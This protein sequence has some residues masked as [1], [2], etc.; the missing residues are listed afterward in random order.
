MVDAA[1]LMGR[2]A[3][4]DNAAMEAEPIKAEPLKRKRRWL[5]CSPER[6]LFGLLISEG[7]LLLS[8]RFRWFEFNEQKGWTVLIAVASA[9]IVVAILPVW[10]GIAL[11]FRWRFQFGIRSLLVLVLTIAIPCGWLA[12]ERNKANQQ[13]EAVAAISTEGEVRYAYWYDESGKEIVHAQTTTSPLPG[14]SSLP[15]TGVTISYSYLNGKAVVTRSYTRTTTTISHGEPPGP[16]WLQELFGVDFFSDV[17]TANVRTDAGLERAGSLSELRSLIHTSGL[18][19]SR[20]TDAGL[21]RISGL[22][23]L[24]RL[25]LSE[26]NVTD[27][28]LVSL[29]D[30]TQL[31]DLSLRATRIT[32]AGL[33]HL[34]ALNNLKYLSL[35][36]TQVTDQ[37]VVKLRQKLPNCQVYR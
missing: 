17:A 37:G 13:R 23:R 34:T 21:K 14:P 36:L 2:P 10:F 19:P 4:A 25:D 15:G 33:T 1:G 6:V 22:R 9:A 12:A 7:L 18:K 30:L 28:G 35:G 31:R 32:D 27:V 8:E 5:S 16:A 26:T 20:I 29:R 3:S 11:V 24:R